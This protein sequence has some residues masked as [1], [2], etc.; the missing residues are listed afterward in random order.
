MN[1]VELV[2][3]RVS[4]RQRLRDTFA[5]YNNNNRH[6]DNIQILTDG[7]NSSNFSHPARLRLRKQQKFSHADCRTW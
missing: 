7:C 5:T 1:L 6:Y 3:F 4:A 2:F